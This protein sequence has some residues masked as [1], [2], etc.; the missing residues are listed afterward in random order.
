M[1]C[2]ALGALPAIFTGHEDAVRPLAFSPD[3]KWLASGSADSRIKIWD[4]SSYDE[5]ASLPGHRSLM[6]WALAFSRD[7]A[8]FAS[9][10]HSN[11]RQT[12]KLWDARRLEVI[13]W[14]TGHRGYALTVT[15]SADGHRLASGGTDG[16]IRLWNVDALRAA[17]PAGDGRGS[18]ALLRPFLARRPYA[19][20]AVTRLIEDIEA[21]TKL[22][23]VGTDAMLAAGTRGDGDER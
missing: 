6:V 9:A 12:V 18:G 19:D 15:F 22:E 10:S 20:E 2:S 3:G 8:L 1:N 13:D 16:T 14:L 4:T 7:G 23:L 5:I 21:I 11:D 17:S